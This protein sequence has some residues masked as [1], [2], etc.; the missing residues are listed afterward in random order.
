MGVWSCRN[1]LARGSV[2]E[3]GDFILNTGRERKWRI[4][5]KEKRESDP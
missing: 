2:E 3:K 4:K 1:K 5:V